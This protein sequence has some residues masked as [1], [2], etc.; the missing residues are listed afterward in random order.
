MA[1]FFISYTQ[2]DRPWAEW[3]TRT[4]VEAGFTVW[5]QAGPG[6]NFILNMETATAEADRTIAVLSPHYFESKPC[7][8]EWTAAFTLG[9][10]LPVRVRSMELKGLL[11]PIVYIDCV[12]L[13]DTDAKAALLTGIKEALA[14]P[15]TQAKVPGR[16]HTRFPADLSRLPQDEIPEVGSLPHGS[17]MPFFHNPLFVGREE[18]LKKL[19]REL[20]VGESTTVGEVRTAAVTGLGGIGKTQLAVEFAYRYSGFFKGGVFWL[21]FADPVSLPDEVIACGEALN[22][23]P[24]YDTL[25]PYQ[26]LHLVKEEWQEACARLLVFD[27]CES[28]ADFKDWRPKA[29]G[30]RVLVTSR[31]ADWDAYL[32]IRKVP[33]D[34]LRRAA[35]VDLLR[36]FRPDFPKDDPVV[37]VIASELGDLPLALHL[38]G[39][40]LSFLQR[41]GDR[42]AGEAASYLTDLRARSLGHPS[43]QGRTANGSPTSHENNVERT[44]AL[45]FERLDPTEHVDALARSLLARAAFFAPGK[46][47]PRQL[48]MA[49]V[50]H[51]P[52]SDELTAAEA[53]AR[54][55][56][57]GLLE[58]RGGTI[59]IHPLVASF[60]SKREGAEVARAVVEETVWQEANRINESGAPG[61]LVPWQAHL[62]AITDVAFEREDLQVASLCSALHSHLSMLSDLVVPWR[63]C[64]R[65]WTIRQKILGVDHP[66]T[67]VSRRAFEALQQKEAVLDA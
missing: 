52:G 23:H 53:L 16:S 37:N 44:F 6:E 32:G 26:R 11:A 51:S 25:P 62:I 66:E 46:P 38:A 61:S 31:R 43:L 55:C 35:S 13:S 45:S 17:R 7:R 63:Y 20:K 56:D 22:L 49:T 59:S 41:Y 39:S 65:A 28:P 64:V 15:G 3:I 33:L 67:I 4:L 2:A 48:L 50:V 54:L 27:N 8:A 47:I 57:L 58:A 60:V 5:A 1:D 14:K 42:A 40:F 12:G 36:R 24:S 9:K 30:A 29:G 19:A 21:N 18:D 10:L 34:V